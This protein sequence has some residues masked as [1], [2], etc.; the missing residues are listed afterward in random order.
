MESVTIKRGKRCTCGH[1]L[2]LQVREYGM[3]QYL[4]CY[5]CGKTYPI[6]YGVDINGQA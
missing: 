4:K 6:D 3:V 5:K 2:A 1:I